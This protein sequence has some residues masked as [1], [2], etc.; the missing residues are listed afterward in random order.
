MKVLAPPSPISEA[1]GGNEKELKT[2]ANLESQ[3]VAVVAAA[4]KTAEK[5]A[6]VDL[7][8]QPVPAPLPDNDSIL[9][10]GEA[11]IGVVPPVNL[12]QLSRLREK[13]ENVSHLRTLAV[14]GS[15]NDGCIMTILMS[16]P[17]PL[18]HILRGTAEIEKANF[19]LD[20]P[21]RS[22]GY[23]P[24]WMSLEPRSGGLKGNRLVVRLRR[25][26]IRQR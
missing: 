12:T 14:D 3:P 7:M 23:F 19:W 13:L 16:K 6:A 21:K 5:T 11:E 15:W 26:L 22:D 20:G 1:H 18:I 25:D 24:G 17:S 8:N 2:K 4:T 10:E 9:F